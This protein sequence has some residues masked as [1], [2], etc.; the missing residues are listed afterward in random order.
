MMRRRHPLLNRRCYILET[1][2][3]STRP[4]LV[5]QNIG[6]TTALVCSLL[7]ADPALPPDLSVRALFASK[8]F[9]TTF[10]CDANV[11]T[12]TWTPGRA[13]NRL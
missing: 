10:A 3:A 8:T 6:P 1:W 11:P 4:N 2:R 5:P 9:P 7:A 13:S 12:A